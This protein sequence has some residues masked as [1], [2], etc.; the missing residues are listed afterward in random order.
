MC[1]RMARIGKFCYIIEIRD[2]AM[3]S[4]KLHT[5]EKLHAKGALG[6]KAISD[7]FIDELQN[8]MKSFL[9]SF[10]LVRK[11]TNGFRILIYFLE[12]LN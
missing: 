3:N 1:Q 5:N 4:Q 10:L 2:T 9:K 7:W 8:A 12:I 6:L 11:K